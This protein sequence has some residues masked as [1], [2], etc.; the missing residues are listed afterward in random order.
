MTTSILALAVLVYIAGILG[1]RRSRTGLLAYLWGAF[2][3]A[4]ILVLSAQLGGW[5][6][7]A[8]AFQASILTTLA[9][10]VG[11]P[12]QT[13]APANLV[14][15]DPT[16]WSILAIG[17]ECSTVIEAAVF[18][19]LLLFYP[20]V[21]HGERIGRLAIGLAGTVGINLLRLAVIVAMVAILGKPAVP[22]AHTVVGRVVF[23]VGVVFLYWRL[24]TMPT[25][26]I[27]RRD[28]EVSG[29]SVV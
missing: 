20:R 16:G 22:W 18:A 2:G 1:L 8:G 19:G 6:Q 15:P 25:L 11:F 27:V 3:L 23:F 5:N 26:H 9:N 14:V 13:M 4:A 17:V 7:P 24:M 28:L 10:G 12:L 29:R 21:S